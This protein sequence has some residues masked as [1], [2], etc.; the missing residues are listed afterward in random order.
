ARRHADRSHP[1]HRRRGDRGGQARGAPG[2]SAARR[3]AER[4][5]PPGKPRHGV[6]A[7]AAAG[8]QARP[9]H[10][11]LPTPVAQPPGARAAATGVRGAAGRKSLPRGRGGRAEG[12]GG[13]DRRSARQGVDPGG[14]V[15]DGRRSARKRSADGMAR[16]GGA[17][18]PRAGGDA[19]GNGADAPAAG[20]RRAR[21]GPAD[22]GRSRLRSRH[23]RDA[24]ARA[25]AAR[26]PRRQAADRGRRA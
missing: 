9:R 25:V 18:G 6:P 22:R 2:R 17:C 4:R 8:A 20:A 10:E 26:G 14:W 19:A 3:V 16:A 24:A 23:R 12:G 13:D 5:E 21:V 1:V 15:A 7:L 11:R